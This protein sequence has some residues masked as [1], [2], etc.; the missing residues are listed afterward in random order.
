[1]TLPRY[2]SALIAVL[3]LTSA[4][5]GAPRTSLGKPDLEAIREASTDPSSEMYYPKLLKTFM[6]NDTLMSDEQF[7]YFYYGTLFQDSYDPYR[8]VYRPKELDVLRPLYQKSNPSRHERQLMAD[9]AREAIGDNPVNLQQLVHAIDVMERNN[10]QN[11]AGIWQYKLNHLLLVIASS[12]AGTDPVTARI[13]VYPQHE[14]DF[15]NLAGYTATGHSF[16]EPHYDYITVSQ[17]TPSDPDGFYFD[18]SEMLRQYYLRHP[19]ELAGDAE[20]ATD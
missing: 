11:L 16:E 13:V 10:K 18:I 3:T 17:R 15:L 5:Y 14:Y 2:I 7:Q 6:S 9:Y 19:D 1:M 20:G 12:G 8:P 4:A